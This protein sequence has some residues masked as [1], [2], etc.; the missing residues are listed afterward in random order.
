MTDEP[1]GRGGESGDRE[2]GEPNAANHRAHIAVRGIAAGQ[3][4]H[5]P[6]EERERDDR[7]HA[8]E[9][10]PDDDRWRDDGVEKRT[11]PTQHGPHED[12]HDSEDHDDEVGAHR[13][14]R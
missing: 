7:R 8:D 4:G 1:A 6:A 14:A 10:R 13:S 3:R 11:R 5:G 2:E 9:R 12:G